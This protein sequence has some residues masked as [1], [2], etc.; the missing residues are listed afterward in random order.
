MVGS[1]SILIVDSME[2]NKFIRNFTR[3]LIDYS[4]QAVPI[5]DLESYFR[6]IC[7]L[8]TIDYYEE[9]PLSEADE[10]IISGA[11]LIPSACCTN[12]GGAWSGQDDEFVKVLP[13]YKQ[14]IEGNIAQY[15]AIVMQKL[16]PTFDTIVQQIYAYP[17]YWSDYCNELQRL[18]QGNTPFK[19]IEHSLQVWKDAIPDTVLHNS[20]LLLQCIYLSRKAP[21]KLDLSLPIQVKEVILTHN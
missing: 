19:A 18:V 13:E 11:N 20:F 16:A 3:L 6:S 2:T 12:I 21:F 4:D 5:V 7:S 10:G 15:I 17:A 14:E 1:F 9:P 8:N